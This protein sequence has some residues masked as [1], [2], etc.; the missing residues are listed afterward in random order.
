MKTD[1]AKAR[2]GGRDGAVWGAEGGGSREGGGGDGGSGGGV[3]SLGCVCVPSPAAS[4]V[5]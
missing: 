2:W 3:F 5:G 4:P 1:W